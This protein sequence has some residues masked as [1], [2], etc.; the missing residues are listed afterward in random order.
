MNN[1][2]IANSAAFDIMMELNL[3]PD[4]SEYPTQ[5]DMWD[6]MTEIIANHHSAR[7]IDTI[8]FRIVWDADWLV[9]IPVEFPDAGREKLQKIIDKVFKTRRG[10]QMAVESLKTETLA[11]RKG[12]A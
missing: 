4:T 7:D 3:H 8:E 5:A 12:R 2:D 6:K 9:N 1:T 11:I 10:R